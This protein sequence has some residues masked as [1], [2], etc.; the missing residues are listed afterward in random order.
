M[1]GWLIPV[2]AENQ[3]D[4]SEP[5]KENRMTQRLSF[6]EH[7]ARLRGLIR[8]CSQGD[9][10]PPHFR[11]EAFAAEFNALAS[12]LFTLQYDRVP[13]YRRFCQARGVDSGGV[14][15]WYDIPAIPAAAFKD[16]DL[17]SL[18]VEERTAVFHSSGTTTHRPSR[19]FHNAESLE[20]YEASLLPWFGRH[21]LPEA[22]VQQFSQKSPTPAPLPEGDLL[23]DVSEQAPL[24]GRGTEVVA[25]SLHSASIPRFALDSPAAESNFRFVILTPCPAR[26]PN[27]SLVYMLETVRREFAP[28]RADF[29]GKLDERGGW[30]LDR[31]LAWAALAQATADDQSVVLLGTAFSLV[32]LLD[33]LNEKQRRLQLP[34][35][36]RVLETGGYKGRSRALTKTELYGLIT[37][38]LGIPLTRIVCEYGMS[39]LS[40]QAYDCVAGTYESQ[41]SNLKFEI[42]ERRFRFPP[43]AKV[44][45]ISPETGRE[46]GEGETGLI[47][48]FDLANLRSVM[49]IQTEDLGT[50][51]GDGFK[52]LG[53]AA[54]AE[55]RGCSLLAV[56]SP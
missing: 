38:R 29:A 46:V 19:H 7:I 24:P 52:V 51:Q 32:E 33:W 31:D 25:P 12:A 37:D 9:Q 30:I 23:S 4:S 5:P 42:A 11:D 21:V 54:L 13:A 40:S 49:A 56:E 14:A 10:S 2:V 41:I 45:I 20:V 26:A 43:W 15:R 8:R 47:R 34:P 39:E 17:S 16:F 35:G 22:D 48:V 44:Q 36:S 53:R 3:P 28:N 55:P 27:S 1:N 18:P 50:R 6:Q